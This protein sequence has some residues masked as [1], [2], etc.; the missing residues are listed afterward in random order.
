MIGVVAAERR[1]GDDVAGVHVHHDAERAVLNFVALNGI[2]E[3]L[4]Q[5]ILHRRVE[6]QNQT[7]TVG[8]VVIF[9]VGVE[10][11]RPAVA[12]RGH[13][14]AARALQV[15]VVI[16]LDALRAAVILTDKAQHLRRQRRIRIVALR[17]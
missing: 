5:H 3:I 9:F 10:H 8:R 7:V 14:L 17:V 15:A 11:F 1:H 13:D 6:R 12:A 16:R 2:F 4:F